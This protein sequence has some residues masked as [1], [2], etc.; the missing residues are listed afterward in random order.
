MEVCFACGHPGSAHTL[1]V[2]ADGEHG[3]SAGC[4]WSDPISAASCA[5]SGFQP[6]SYDL[7]GHRINAILDTNVFIEIISVYDLNKAVTDN[8]NA[9]TVRHRWERAR[10]ALLLSLMLHDQHATT[11]SLREGERRLGE[12]VSPGQKMGVD[13]DHDFVVFHIHVVKER[14]LSDWTSVFPRPPETVFQE[15]ADDLLLATAQRNRLPLITNEGWGVHGVFDR[16]LRKQAKAAGVAVFTTSEFIA[17]KC[18]EQ[19]LAFDFMDRLSQERPVE[20]ERRRAQFG[21]NDQ[22]DAL[23]Q[24]IQDAC[25]VLLYGS[26]P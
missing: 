4:R 1:D 6:S 17:G 24:M 2:T 18:N 5:C 23:F 10:S 22:G 3:P 12:L 7:S 9:K 8:A 15:H 19:K 16:G 26:P 25:R 21:D 11:L 14:L 20:A 13:P